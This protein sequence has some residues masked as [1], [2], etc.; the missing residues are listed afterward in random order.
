M[1]QAAL[2]SRVD[3]DVVVQS[4]GYFF[5]SIRA[6]GRR[7]EWTADE[8]QTGIG[9]LERLCAAIQS[10]AFLATDSADD[11]RWCDYASICGD[12]KR[13]TSMSADLAN[14][15]EL[16]ELRMVRELRRD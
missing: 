13:V 3:P 7:I 6:L 11:C 4:F 10:G 2:R 14:R 5:P 15:N 12:V 8:L 1:V 9:V 16:V